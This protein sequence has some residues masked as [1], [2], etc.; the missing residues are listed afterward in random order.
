MTDLKLEVVEFPAQGS[1]RRPPLLFIHGAYTAAWCWQTHF[2]PYFAARGY[3]GFALS[4]RAHGGSDGHG[5]LHACSVDDYVAD[6]DSVL[7][8]VRQQCGQSPVLVGHSMGGFLALQLARQQAVAGIAL[9]ATVPPE[10][11]IGSALHLFWQHPQLLLELNLVQHA[12]RPPQLAKLRELLFSADLPE[13]ELLQYANRLQQESDRALVD[14]TLPQWDMRP[15]LG[16]PPALVLASRNDVLMPV[17]LNH[18]AARF[19]GVRAQ[20]LDGIGHLMML[21]AGWEKAASA[22][23]DWLEELP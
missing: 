17:H 15:P 16:N 5:H 18:C 13:S 4:L 6:I 12:N 21:D 11:L 10:G 1:R 9:L 8:Q 19:L 2:L 22:L 7:Q 3:H 23:A 20:L 14:M